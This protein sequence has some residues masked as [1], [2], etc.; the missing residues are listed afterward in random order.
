MVVGSLQYIPDS[1]LH[2]YGRILYIPLDILPL[3]GFTLV[4]V[5]PEQAP[6]MRHYLLMACRVGGPNLVANSA[7]FE[8]YKSVLRKS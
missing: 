8:I 6:N 2:K 7:G 5:W 1:K 3:Q 4:R